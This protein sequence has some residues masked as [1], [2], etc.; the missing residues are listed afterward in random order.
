MK[1]AVIFD[2]DGT[3]ADTLNSIKYCADYAIGTCG[4]QPIPLE[5]Y[6]VFIGDGAEMLIR[7]ALQ[8][9]GD[10]DCAY[11]DKAFTQYKC[12][13]KDNCMYQVRPYDGM[14]ECLETLKNSGV[15]LAVFSNKP[16]A[17][18]IEVVE[19]LFGKDCFHE[20]LG[21][22]EL[23]PRKPS[24]DGMYLLAEKLGVKSEDIAYVGDTSTDMITGK[25]AGVF[26]IG[27]L[28]GFRERTELEHFGADVIV[29]HPLD[30]LEQIG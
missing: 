17:R 8:Y 23:V 30:I 7:R 12:F 10:I 25:S 18:T 14:K 28:W 21:Q 11:I 13:F 20:I 15:K 9:S 3:L 6:K 26:T 19:T 5:K 22:G 29:E 27:V 4:F 1:K 24:P 2:L 16:H